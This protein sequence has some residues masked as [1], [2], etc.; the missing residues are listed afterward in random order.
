[1]ANWISAGRETSMHR[2]AKQGHSR[3]SCPTRWTTRNNPCFVATL[4]R[5][6]RKR[7]R[8]VLNSWNWP[9]RLWGRPCVDRR[10]GAREAWNSRLAQNKQRET[11]LPRGFWERESTSSSSSLWTS[12]KRGVMFLRGSRKT[13]SLFQQRCRRSCPLLWETVPEAPSAALAVDC[14][15]CQINLPKSRS[16]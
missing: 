14:T 7:D 16:T 13:R 6:L 10:D 8:F 11:S 9:R 2:N 5:L 4:G 1:M 12:S 15:A 3:S